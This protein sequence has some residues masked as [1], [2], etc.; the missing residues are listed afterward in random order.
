MQYI[1]FK[2]D[3]IEYTIPILK[4]R[5]IINTP[6]VTQV[7]QSPPYIEGV[8]NLRGSITMIVNLRKLLNIP[9]N[10]NIGTK[11]IIISSGKITFGVLVD[12]ITGVIDIDEAAVE[13]PERFFNEK[14]EQIKGV[15][16]IND[17]LLVLLEPRK[18]V[19]LEDVSLF[20]D[21]I[22]D[23]KQGADGKMEL[24]RSVQTMAGEVK[25]KELVDA[26]EFFEKKKDG[27]PDGA[28]ADI[29]SFLDHISNHEYEKADELIQ[30][31]MKKGQGQL[32]N[33]LGKVTRKLHDSI[34]TF[35]D[36][37]DPKLKDMA[38]HEMPSAVERINYVI[39][40]TEEAA[41]KTMSIVEKY[42]LSMD[43]F[44]GHIRT[45]KEPEGT[46][47]YLRKFKNSLEDDLT[48]VLTTQSFQ[49]LTGQ[50]LKKVIE[51]VKDIEDELV[52]LI[53]TFGLKLDTG[54]VAVRQS[55]EKVSQ[56]GVDD[57]LKDLGF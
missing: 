4:V 45:L 32:Y 14:M 50:A 12:G 5:E 34:K 43:E 6:Q 47:E 38:T 40:K 9:Q 20:E 24:V 31:I 55:A 18:L 2:L 36:A 41:N 29:V 28:V 11:I 3:S 51:L 15:A 33:E 35:S 22:V 30:K 17:K 52:R 39:E 13:H 48:E 10:G 53:T 49:D 37:I 44:A 56:A 54:G 23:M 27:S 19:P 1:G 42:T 21:N 25:V 26:K 57:L 7:P 46:V 8:M 16:K